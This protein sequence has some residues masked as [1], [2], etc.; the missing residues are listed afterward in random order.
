MAA[1]TQQ[2]D[3]ETR[4]DRLE[5]QFELHRLVSEYCHGCDK[6]DIDRFM[7]IWHDDA[8]WEIGAPFG[9]FKGKQEIRRAMEEHIWP[10]WRETH[11]W[12]TNLVVEIDGD[13]AHGVCDVNCNGASPEDVALLVSA[14]YTDDF[15]RRDG[16]WAISRRHVVIHYFSPVPGVDLAPPPPMP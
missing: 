7:S 3:L 8:V 1:Q 5:S 2:L 13:R 9:T 10:A 12:T 11:H 16:R 6:H 14:T 4:I 15:E